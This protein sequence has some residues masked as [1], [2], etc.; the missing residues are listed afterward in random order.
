MIG[1]IITVLLALGL[2]LSAGHGTHSLQIEI[3]NRGVGAIRAV[4]C[5]LVPRKSSEAQVITD[6]NEHKVRWR[7]VVEPFDGKPVSIGV[8][9]F[10]RKQDWLGIKLI[11]EFSQTER[12]L[13]SAEYQDVRRVEKV[14][15]IPDVRFSDSVK[16]VFP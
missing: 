15:Q 13:L 10:Y 12:L 3:D 16:V 8:P 1:A 7:T 11:D 2:N 4:K 6:S 14:V 9:F 5:A